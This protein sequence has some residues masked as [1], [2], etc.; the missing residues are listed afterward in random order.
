MVDLALGGAGH[1]H[2][3]ERRHAEHG[4]AAFAVRRRDDRRVHVDEA[5]LPKELV[6][7]ERQRAPHAK[8]GAKRVR[9]RPQVSD[10]AQ[11]FEGVS[12]LLE[13]VTFRIR[14]PDDAQRACLEL[15]AL[16]RRR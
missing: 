5:S 13:G 2:E 11:E 8:D 1:V 7:G 10:F 14:G 6:D 4:A 9:A 16:P 12:L 3:V 15:D